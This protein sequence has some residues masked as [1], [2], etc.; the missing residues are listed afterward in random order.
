M[1]D[2]ETNHFLLKGL[3]RD[4]PGSVGK[5]QDNRRWGFFLPQ[6]P[7]DVSINQLQDSISKCLSVMGLFLKQTIALFFESVPLTVPVEEDQ[8]EYHEDRVVVELQVGVAGPREPPVQLAPVD[9]QSD[10]RDPD[11]LRRPEHRPERRAGRIGGPSAGIEPQGLLTWKRT[12][13]LMYAH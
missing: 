6:S 1:L 5:T 4:L 2:R 12:R 3:N 7:N 9:G 13:I 11:G 10:G 8:P